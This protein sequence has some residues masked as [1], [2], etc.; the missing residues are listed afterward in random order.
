MPK[1]TIGLPVYNAEGT[2][3]RALKGLLSQT[4]P[5]IELLISDNSSTDRTYE[6]CAAFAA[7][8]SR[9]RLRQQEQNI[10]AARNFRYVLDNASCEFFM[11]AAA[12]DFHSPDF[13]AR[14]LEFLRG[15][16]EYAG[17]ISPVQFPDDPCP[18]KTIGDMAID[19]DCP[20]DRLASYI[21]CWHRNSI[22]Y[23]VY[24]TDS[25]RKTIWRG[26]PT[27]GEDWIVMIRILRFWKLG[28]I[29]SGA[30]IR[31]SGGASNSLGVF[32]PMLSG[33]SHFMFPSHALV[34]TI[35]DE[36]STILGRR[37]LIAACCFRV[38]AGVP[39]M[40]LIFFKRW[41]INQGKL[42]ACTR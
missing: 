13:I 11:W 9:I 5:C 35:L 34:R 20:L 42:L 12:D 3:A 28:R 39:A 19:Q 18:S 21:D 10:G 40:W 14:N 26:D 23:G 33:L 37:V 17:S 4:E 2:I 7:S 38:M 24:R 25:L 31:S 6:I 22:F 30:L 36:Y 1:I 27:I 32:S 41:L 29:D 8:D 15:H 16:P